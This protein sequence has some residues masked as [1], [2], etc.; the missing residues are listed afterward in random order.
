MKSIKRKSI[1]YLFKDICIENFKYSIKRRKLYDIDKPSFT[2]EDEL[3]SNACISNRFLLHMLWELSDVYPNLAS[4]IEVI[5][6]PAEKDKDFIF[7]D[8]Y[9]DAAIVVELKYKDEK[10]VCSIINCNSKYPNGGVCKFKDIPKY[11]P[12]GDHTTLSAC[13]PMCFFVNASRIDGKISYNNAKEFFSSNDYE[14]MKNNGVWMKYSNEKENNEKEN[15]N[16]N[17][18]NENEKKSKIRI[19]KDVDFPQVEFTHERCQLANIGGNAFITLPYERSERHN[20]CREDNFIVGDDLELIKNGGISG[21]HSKTYCNAFYKDYIEETRTCEETIWDKIFSYTFLGSTL[22]RLARHII[23][24]GDGCDT[25]FETDKNRPEIDSEKINNLS[26]GTKYKWFNN[27]DKNFSIPPPNILLSDLGLDYRD[28]NKEWSSSIM[29]IRCRTN[30][31]KPNDILSNFDGRISA[32]KLMQKINL[33][34]SEEK[35]S[36]KIFYPFGYDNNDDNNND[37]N[38]LDFDE[39]YDI[40]GEENGSMIIDFLL[41]ITRDVGITAADIILQFLLKNFFKKTYSKILVY[42]GNRLTGKISKTLLAMGLRSGVA[43]ISAM[44]LTRL[45]SRL[46]LILGTTASVIGTV[47]GI[48]ELIGLLLDVM[49]LIGWDPGNYSSEFDNALYD[50]MLLGWETQKSVHESMIIDPTIILLTFLR[51]DKNDED[52]GERKENKRHIMNFNNEKDI[53]SYFKRYEEAMKIAMKDMKEDE[54]DVK[55]PKRKYN[56]K[57]YIM[58]RKNMIFLNNNNNDDDDDDDILNRIRP[59]MYDEPLLCSIVWSAHYFSHRQYNSLGQ[60]INLDDELDISDKLIENNVINNEVSSMLAT[61]GNLT[62]E[63]LL[64]AMYRNVQEKFYFVSN[65]SVLLVFLLIG[66]I[67]DSILGIYITLFIMISLTIS[68]IVILDL[69]SNFNNIDK[70]FDR[71]FTDAE[72]NSSMRNDGDIDNIDRLCDYLSSILKN[73]NDDDETNNKEEISFII[74]SLKNYFD[75]EFRVIY[76][77]VET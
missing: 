41:S 21:R 25:K 33:L 52:D 29:N 5:I 15:S 43:K 72:P 30:F 8:N 67:L 40:L 17:D 66:I 44:V 57:E 18:D 75:Q 63:S 46:M 60:R 1:R 51:E 22:V 50:D 36:R 23:D 56:G 10:K 59:F 6:R 73:Y 70:S 53:P 47:I 68:L 34:S 4:N 3:S 61:R 31:Q 20:I 9:A 54:P 74:N 49:T 28:K 39:I 64:G 62:R 24:G 16:N 69:I 76:D 19:I 35:C 55:N 2:S 14:I 13:N 38:L 27:Y 65:I 58:N 77:V 48:I 37:D 11:Y 71:N 12:S 32:R 42:I 26:Y 45:S 7:E